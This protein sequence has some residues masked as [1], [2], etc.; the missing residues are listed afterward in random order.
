MHIRDAVKKESKEVSIAGWIYRKRESGGIAFVIIRDTTGTLQ[1]AIKKDKVDEHSWKDA[2]D[3]TIESSAK[4][5]G[6][7][8]KDERA[9]GG[10]EL[11]ASW[12]RTVHVSEPFP[13]TEYQSAEL[14]LDKRH[15]WLRSRKMT[16]VMRGRS[17]IFK[18]TR[19]FLDRDGFYEITPPVITLAGGETGAD[20]FEVN[21]FGQKAY[22]T[23]SS[24]LYAES[25]I[26]SLEKVYSF[27]PAFR[28]EKSRTTK[29]LAELWMLEPE[30]AYYDIK[31][32]MKLQEKLVSYIANKLVKD[33]EDILEEMKVDKE[34]LLKVRPPFKRISYEKSL[35]IL[36][37]KGSKLKW[38]DDFGV[39][40][41]KLL[42]E[43][44]EKPIF[45]YNWP[46][47]LKP[48]YA[49]INPDDTRTALSADMQAP[50]GH[51]EI[52]GGTQREWRLNKVLERMQEVEKIK[53]IKFDMKN[54]EW[55]LD[56]RRYGSVPHSGFGMG[57]ERVI[58]WLFNLD[59]IRD[60]IPFPRMMNRAYP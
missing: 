13:I 30:M 10:Y 52:I 60:A 26:F 41:E 36:N 16:Q 3:G 17:H 6:I 53:G 55:W 43:G 34:S 40:E 4:V 15:L 49:S 28:A 38:G 45:V 11:E 44:E 22:L 59:H 51:G 24:Q 50:N 37:E 8:K 23:E 35:E 46:R 42:T 32:S 7:V 47:E 27:V 12:F 9:P 58:K 56:L 1:A 33:D 18:H 48:F 21:F 14:L 31:K 57:M 39:P 54:Y 19:E 20:L 2:V 25:M 29:H 5:R